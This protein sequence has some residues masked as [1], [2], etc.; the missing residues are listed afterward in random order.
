MSKKHIAIVFVL[1]FIFTLNTFAQNIS[2][3]KSDRTD[4]LVVNQ[5]STNDRL[6]MH[7]MRTIH[8]AEMT[9]LMTY[10]AGNFGTL[11]L[12]NVADLLDP[13]LAS[14]ERYG[15]RFTLTANSASTVFQSSF[16]L[17]AVPAVRAASRLSFYMNESGDIRGADRGG[18]AATDSDPILESC[19][20]STRSENERLA[21][22]SVRNIHA[23]QVTYQA[24]Y[25]AGNFG[26]M[27][28]L[29]QTNLATTGFALTYRYRGYSSAMTVTSWTPNSPS[30]FNIQIIPE[31]Y[32]RTGIKSYYI[33][34]TGVLRGADKH[35]LAAD[36]N[37]PPVDF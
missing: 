18:R 6:V 2:N 28:Q 34:E 15:Y 3:Q 27:S 10:G 13:A 29:F 21:V 32:G 8:S 31:L 12:L 7:A 14:G 22:Q 35:G 37:D 25:G 17:T 23:A 24:S 16:D 5:L 1:S 26:T 20:F 19:G 36:A 4:S 11:T 30:R 9:Y 33:D